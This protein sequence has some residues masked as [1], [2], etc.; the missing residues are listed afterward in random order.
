V[1]RRPA[2]PDG[3]E[4]L[5]ADLSDGF[6]WTPLGFQTEAPEF[7]GQIAPAGG[8]QHGGDMAAT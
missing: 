1:A 4:T 5:A 6:R 7:I 2:G 8:L 3:A